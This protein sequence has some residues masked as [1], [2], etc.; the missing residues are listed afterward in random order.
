MLTSLSIRTGKSPVQKRTTRLAKYGGEE[1]ETGEKER[2]KIIK[3]EESLYE[4]F[5]CT[6]FRFSIRRFVR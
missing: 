4:L 6:L 3:R 5:I 2:I 1:G